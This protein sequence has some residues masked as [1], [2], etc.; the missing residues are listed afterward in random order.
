M[1]S[2]KTVKGL[3]KYL[4]P[5][6]GYTNAVKEIGRVLDAGIS[7]RCYDKQEGTELVY[8]SFRWSVSPQGNTFWYELALGNKPYGYEDY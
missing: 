2:D 7:V 1:T 4:T 6:I 8:R 5:L 3:I